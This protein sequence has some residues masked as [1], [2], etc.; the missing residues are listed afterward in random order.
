MGV[1]LDGT[2]QSGQI[3]HELRR[4]RRTNFDS[5]TGSWMDE[6]DAGGMEKIA[7]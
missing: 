2:S 3:V 6:S 1:S 4:E 5:L 7:V